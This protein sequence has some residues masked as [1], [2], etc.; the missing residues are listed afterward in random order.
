M[1]DLTD[2]PKTPRSMRRIAV[3]MWR[4]SWPTVLALAAM[5]TAC[6]TNP[7]PSQHLSRGDT[8]A[9]EQKFPEA[10]SEYRQALRENAKDG[11]ASHHLGLAYLRL[12]ELIQ[13]YDALLGAL[14]AEPENA[15]VRRRIATI[16]LT[17]AR[18]EQARDQAYAMM[19]DDSLRGVAL[20][21]LSTTAAT[22]DQVESALKD[23]E[24]SMPRIGRDA[25]ARLALGTLYWRKRDTTAARRALEEGVAT[26]TAA[27]AGHLLL[28]RFYATTGN[29][30]LA[31]REV[32]RAS[33][34]AAP[35]SLGRLGAVE[36]LLF[37]GQRDQARELLAE[38]A[39]QN[40]ADP[41]VWR[42]GGNL[43][44]SDGRLDDAANAVAQLAR[45]TSDVEAAAL[46]GRLHLARQENDRAIADFQRGGR[47]APSV[48]P[49]H[50][51]IAAALIQSGKTNEAKAELE[52]S[53]ALAPLYPDAVF[54]LS[55]LNLRDGAPDAAR[56]TL[57]QFIKS[58]PRSVKAHVLLGA[59]LAATGHAAEA[60]EAFQEVLRIEPNS[61]EGHYWVGMGLAA[62]RRPDE[63]R[64]ELEKALSITP[65]FHE[66]MTQLVLMD[67]R[68]SNPD[69]ALRRV[70]AQLA[71]TQRPADLWDL[72]GLAYA[73]KGQNDSAEVA[74]LKSV[75]LNA[76]L[77][78]PR[79]RL[80]ELYAAAGRADQALIQ[81]EAATKIEP[82]NVRALMALGVAAQQKG[83][84]AKARQAYEAALV[85][86]PRFA[87]P[88]NN[89]ALLLSTQ[90]DDAGALNFALRAQALAPQDPHILD[91]VGWILFKRGE[92]QRAINTLTESAR[93]L[94]ESPGIQYHLGLAAQQAGNKALARESLEKAVNST[95]PFAEKED[96][97]KA[98]LRLK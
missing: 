29:S 81:A 74:F 22:P 68:E 76:T 9:S 54:Q 69:R 73:T 86:E 33:D 43:A 3:G 57:D 78:D 87:G 64:A 84:L 45:D 83:D 49:L 44:L 4:A 35:G 42:L 77:L 10:I 94:P 23:F 92:Y 67:L 65:E 7:A 85:V 40:G 47:L 70:R 93:L 75:Q 8:L 2:V 19:A 6:S 28:S 66:A 26:D 31:A 52:S 89:L 90:G 62:E 14:S 59:A 79:V 15:D 34:I 91:T 24:A 13:A 27:L 39:H 38:I 53:I 5:A 1:A 56:A 58:N 71:V 12:G 98:L 60:A 32:K 21:I 11:R 63:A 95:T 55:E 88:A 72:L 18:R 17:L 96:A 80:S 37:L 48:A 20:T 97:R 51:Y 36:D 46:S 25:R 50:Y 82:K 16:D 30:A 61:S 41:F